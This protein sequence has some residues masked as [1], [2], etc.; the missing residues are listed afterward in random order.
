MLMAFFSA[1]FWNRHTSF[2]QA[3]D[4]KADGYQ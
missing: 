1:M 3:D 4:Y 2:N